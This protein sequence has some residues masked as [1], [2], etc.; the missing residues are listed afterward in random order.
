[1]KVFSLISS[2]FTMILIFLSS[3]IVLRFGAYG[4]LIL[5]ASFFAASLVIYLFRKPLF[6][7]RFASKGSV[8]PYSILIFFLFEA[9]ILNAWVINSVI[10]YIDDSRLLFILLSIVIGFIVV[11][12]SMK[13]GADV[14]I[15]TSI[16][17]NLILL[18]AMAIML[19]NFIYLQKGLETVY[20][21]LIHYHPK[22]LHDSREGLWT[23]FIALTLLF[24]VRLFII[25]FIHSI[26]LVK[27]KSYLLLISICVGSVMLA[28]STMII[29]AVTERVQAMHPN[30][31]IIALLD[32]LMNPYLFAFVWIAMLAGSLISSLLIWTSIARKIGEISGGNKRVFSLMLFLGGICAIVFQYMY[33]R[34]VYVLD[35]LLFFALLQIPPVFVLSFFT[36]K[37]NGFWISYIIIP[38]IYIGNIILFCNTDYSLEVHVIA[39][40]TLTIILITVMRLFTGKV[41]IVY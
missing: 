27:L 30:I 18:F 8:I 28:F 33:L 31:L 19:P 13:N 29:V 21:N 34:E 36:S 22:V 20:H 1:M 32:K 23:L 10:D 38:L 4:G 2:F 16:L 35:I 14:F 3:D 26:G 5:C 11:L 41:I 39:T 25:L 24:T 40:V 12:L 6:A 17:V 37:R 7:T 9:I 15:N